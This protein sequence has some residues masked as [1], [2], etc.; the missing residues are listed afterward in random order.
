MGKGKVV[1][2]N[3]VSLRRLGDR[4][5]MRGLNLGMPVYQLERRGGL[6]S[7]AP[8]VEIAPSTPL[9]SP[10]HNASW[11]SRGGTNNVY[12]YPLDVDGAD[13]ESS[14]KSAFVIEQD[15]PRTRVASGSLK[16]VK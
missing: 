8:N 4:G 3:T 13:S 9:T 10:P 5:E 2:N 16:P 12:L 6:T 11:A 14:M 1:R 15:E 7:S